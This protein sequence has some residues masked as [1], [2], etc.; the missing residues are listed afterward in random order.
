[1]KPDMLTVEMLRNEINFHNRNYYC[2][3]NP[4]IS[5]Q[6]YDVLFRRLKIIESEY[7][8]LVTPD[9]P[10]QRVGG[11]PVDGF[12]QAKHAVPMLSLENAFNQEEFLKWYEEV[13]ESAEKHFPNSP[14]GDV[15]ITAEPKFDGLAISLIYVDGSLVR[16]VTRGDGETGEDVTLNV[17]TIPTVPLRLIHGNLPI[18][19]YLEVRGEAVMLK[20]QLERLN[21]QRLANGEKP[22][23][24]C[25][26][27][28][29]GSIRQLDPAMTA[30]RRL[31]FYAYQVVS[32]EG[33]ERL[34][35]FLNKRMAYHSD[36]ME[37]LRTLGFRTS[38]LNRSFYTY[39][40]LIAHFVSMSNNRETLPFD[41]DGVVFKVDSL[42]QQEKMGFVSR[43]PKW[44]IAFKF[45]AMEATTILEGVD[46][47]IGRTGVLTPVARLKPVNLAGVT[48]S[49]ATLHNMD[50]V[51]RL[52]IQIGDAVFVQRAGD[53]IPKIVDSLPMDS[54]IRPREIVMPANC[55]SC[56]FPVVKDEGGAF[57]RCTNSGLKCPGQMVERL[58]HF[59]SRRAMDID[60]LGEM[61][62][63]QLFNE[64]IINTVNDI[65]RIYMQ[66]DR[67]IGLPGMGEKSVDNL[68][69]AIEKSKD[70]TFGRF[71]FALGIP[72][73]GETTADLV[74]RHYFSV[75]E[76]S[77][78]SEEELMLIPTIG[79]ATA[80]AI[81]AFFTIDNT[82]IVAA[83]ANDMRLSH[84]EVP[85]EQPL[86]GQTWV[87]TGT[88]S[89]MT[90]D[91]A[92][93]LLEKLGANVSSSVSKKTTC[94][95]YGAKAGSKLDDAHR[96]G[97]STM[98]EGEFMMFMETFSM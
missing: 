9:S 86:H 64:G 18:P 3:D 52:G 37:Y 65:Y 85:R 24:N 73:V 8:D 62:V 90:R 69:A 38:A 19:T 43:C 46:F 57:Y 55:P 95:V 88:L 71:L 29:A 92:K 78:A 31:T 60:G 41:I 84:Y 50:E 42:A 39:E 81:K 70:T 74:A 7:P 97:V 26:N 25:R 61:T 79:P 1:M 67:I 30:H 58:I 80:S 54:D 66:R 63:R 20:E 27:A 11:K 53:V 2:A 35:A 13:E 6:E 56:S 16:A 5:D 14:E 76:L 77:E 89:A 32:I 87:L 51:K 34:T 75:L 4:T 94:V 96:H 21:E 28:A 17:R 49:N 10:T 22:L 68:I 93:A 47:Q 40:M 83:L 33:N 72:E 98:S 82:V 59:A 36:R 15:V 45:D 44:A 12:K 48:V 23:A 91:G